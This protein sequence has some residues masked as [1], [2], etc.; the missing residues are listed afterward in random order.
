M[1][2]IVF[3]ELLNVLTDVLKSKPQKPQRPPVEKLAIR[4]CPTVGTVSVQKQQILDSLGHDVSGDDLLRAAEA[5]EAEA[6]AA[7]AARVAASRDDHAMQQPDTAP[8]P[9]ICNACRHGH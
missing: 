4:A 9:A 7:A 5:A 8:A 3:A 2:L 1:L 6:S